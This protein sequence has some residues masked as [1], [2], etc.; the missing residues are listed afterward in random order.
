MCPF[1]TCEFVRV[2]KC[3]IAQDSPHGLT[4]N[5]MGLHRRLCLCVYMHVHLGGA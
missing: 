5:G 1:I 2:Q 3:I 4:E